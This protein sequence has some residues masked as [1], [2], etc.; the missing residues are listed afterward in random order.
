[1]N[2]ATKH[3]FLSAHLGTWLA[4]KH[5]KKE[6]GKMVELVSSAMRIHPKSVPRTFKRLQLR[7]KEVKSRSGRPRIYTSDVLAALY[8]VWEIGDRCC[9]ELLHPMIF[10][11][12][13]I[14]NRDK[15]WNHT[16]EATKKLLQMSE[17]TVKRRVLALQKKHGTHRGI[18][19]TKPSSLKAIIPIFKGPWKDVLPGTGQ[20]DTVAHCGGSL[21]GD[22]I[23]TLDYIDAATYW[24]VPRAQWNKG[25]LATQEGLAEIKRRLPFSI[26]MLHPDTGSEFINYHLKRWC[27]AEGIELTRSEPGKKNDNMYVEERNG[28]VV[29]RYLGYLRYDVPAVVLAMNEVY[30][31]LELYLNHFKAVRRQVSKERVGS[32]YVRTYEPKAKPPYQRILEH[33]AITK[34]IKK[35][36][37]EQHAKLNPLHLKRQIDT[38][39]LNLYKL[40]QATRNPETG[41]S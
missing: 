20:I 1:M 37:R 38:L 29:R 30:D 39:T 21:L 32:K 17:R 19:T 28:H 18:S 36:L 25:Q 10:E 23:Y 5:S 22:F 16:D 11:Y 33:P 41:R 27:D 26:L 6:R 9:G 12:V 24:I 7:G 3:D 2:M 15:E 34:E 35:H 40:Q 14:M 13:K 4:T 31:V 8:D